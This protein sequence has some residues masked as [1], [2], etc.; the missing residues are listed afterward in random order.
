MTPPI[1]RSLRVH[2]LAAIESVQT[3]AAATPSPLVKAKIFS[4]ASSARESTTRSGLRPFGTSLARSLPACRLSMAIV[5]KPNDFANWTPRCP[6]PPIPTMATAARGSRPAVAFSSA[7]HT[8]ACGQVISACPREHIQTCRSCPNLPRHTSM[9]RL[10]QRTVT[11]VAVRSCPDPQPGT[12]QRHRHAGSLPSHAS[13][14]TSG[15]SSCSA[16]LTK[17]SRHIS[18]RRF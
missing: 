17:S 6:R 2:V 9:V 13:H 10:V 7:P 3:T 4:A 8:V 18:Y 15:H 5:V 12:A 16:S 1:R 11:A 14:R